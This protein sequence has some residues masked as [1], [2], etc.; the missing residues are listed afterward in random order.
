MHKGAVVDEQLQS[1][2][3]VPPQDG[4]MSCRNPATV[5]PSYSRLRW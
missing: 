5:F 4:Q 2:Q 1:S 3:V